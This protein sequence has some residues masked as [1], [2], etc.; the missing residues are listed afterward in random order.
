MPV[1]GIYYTT[2]EAADKLGLAHGTIRNAVRRGAIKVERLSAR[3]NLIAQAELDRYA[4]EHQG[5][6]GW[7]TRK[8]PGY[9]PATA[10][11]AYQRAWRARKKQQQQET[12]A[13]DDENAP[14]A[15]EE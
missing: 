2:K 11:S 1:E 12:G 9:T 10:R 8:A 3:Q 15:H 5:G 7:E 14:V 4:T 6:K 13:P